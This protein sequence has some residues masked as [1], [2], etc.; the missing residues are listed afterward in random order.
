VPVEEAE[1]VFAADDAASIDSRLDLANLLAQL[2]PKMRRAI[3]FVKLDG[4]SVGEAAAR[5]GMSPSAIKYP[6]IGG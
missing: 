6:Y 2:T 4:L 3:E 5:T 1:G